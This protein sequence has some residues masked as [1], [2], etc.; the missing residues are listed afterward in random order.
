M[1]RVVIALPKFKRYFC[2]KKELKL[3]NSIS[4]ETDT[5]SHGLVLL[6]IGF[7]NCLY[8]FMLYLFEVEIKNIYSYK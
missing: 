5:S 7:G 1:L 4:G 2:L 6:L 3:S 8:F